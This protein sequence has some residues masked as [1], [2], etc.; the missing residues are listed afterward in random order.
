MSDVTDAILSTQPRVSE[1][2]GGWLAVS[3]QGSY[4]HVGVNGDSELD[5]R[6][7]FRTEIEAWA[8]LS[9]LPDRPVAPDA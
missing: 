1:T 4:I 2:P 5:A 7:R 6:E 8:A 9:R 3:A